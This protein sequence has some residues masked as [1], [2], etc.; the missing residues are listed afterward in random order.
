[1][2][3]RRSG[4][5]VAAAA[6]LG[7]GLRES[8][9]EIVEASE[10]GGSVERIG[11]GVWARSARGRR[12]V[13]ISASRWRSIERSR[14]VHRSR[15][16]RAGGATE[17]HRLARAGCSH[18]WR[19]DHLD[20]RVARGEEI[21]TWRAREEPQ[22][23][24]RE[25]HVEPVVEPG[26]AGWRG[27]RANIVESGVVAGIL[28]VAVRDDAVTPFLSL[29]SQADRPF[30]ARDAYVAALGRADRERNEADA[31]DAVFGAFWFADDEV[32]RGVGGHGSGVF[33][34]CFLDGRCELATIG[35]SLGLR[36]CVARPPSA[37]RGRF[38]DSPA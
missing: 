24:S 1:M 4:I 19:V 15:G 30:G 23:D 21:A 14:H 27:C 17:A 25:A 32:D 34:D 35:G 38:G 8:L 12:I 7:P 13:R 29:D 31:Y 9:S 28:G 5:G 20:R 11:T 2:R 22:V 26:A 6:A 36:G 3:S 37:P 18:A 33:L 10:P 16:P